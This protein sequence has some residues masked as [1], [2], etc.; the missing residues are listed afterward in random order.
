[1]SWQFGI[2]NVQVS[3]INYLIIYIGRS[4]MATCYL[5]GGNTVCKTFYKLTWSAASIGG[6]ASAEYDQGA[7]Q[8]CE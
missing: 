6:V 7:I 5:N 3:D 1:M 4:G 8:A 2:L